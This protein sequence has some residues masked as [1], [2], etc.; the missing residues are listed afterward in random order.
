[1]SDM[2]PEQDSR[3]RLEQMIS[4]ANNGGGENFKLGIIL[5]SVFVLVLV[6]IFGVY[7]ARSKSLV[8]QISSPSINQE[9]DLTPAA[10]NATNNTTKVKKNSVQDSDND[11]LSDQDETGVYK[12][13]TNNSDTDGDGLTDRE[14]VKVYKTDPLKADTD[15]D[16]M[17]D[18]QE[19]KS[20]RNPLDSDPDAIWPPRPTDLST[21]K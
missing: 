11:G 20:R 12:T 14:E 10:N 13:A 8:G 17:N 18:G 4:Q 5:L 15:N 3:Q 19:I 16:G 7:L 6:V 21:K 1:M 9:S 2:K